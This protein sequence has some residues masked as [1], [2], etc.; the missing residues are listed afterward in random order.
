M[1]GRLI[2][3]PLRVSVRG[4]QLW[5]RAAEEVA[6]RA[7]LGAMRVVSVFTRDG[8]NGG[9]P[10]STSTST[11]PTSTST[12]T[13]PRARP[14][15]AQRA[16]S[17]PP[18]DPRAQAVETE[19]T[20]PPPVS[21]DEAAER[22]DR[23]PDEATAPFSAPEPSHVSEEATLVREEAEPG[24]EDG[25]GAAVTVREPWEGYARMSAREVIA[26]LA[27][28]TPAELAAVSLYETGNRSRQTV[29]EAVQ[30]QLRTANGGGGGSQD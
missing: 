24:A 16:Q 30:R 5:F 11:P 4:A 23:S 1:V 26:R 22:I 19:P 12:S 14:Q 25:A 15:R 20:P 9:S 28:A 29:L 27:D 13:P 3:F 10:T 17:S 21:A 2:T 7:T 18:R 8:D 6:G